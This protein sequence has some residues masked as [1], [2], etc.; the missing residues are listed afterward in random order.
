[1][2]KVPATAPEILSFYGGA[3]QIEKKK[4]GDHYRFKRI[5]GDKKD[6]ILFA[7]SIT[8]NLDKSRALLPWAV[9]LVGAHITMTLEGNGGDR[10]YHRDEIVL[11][12]QEA[13]MKPEEAKVKG[14]ST[15][16]IIHTF[17]HDFAK[18]ILDP[19]NCPMPT[20]DHLDEDNDDEHR[21]AINGINAF[22]DWYNSRKVEFVAMEEVVYY[23]SLLSGDTKEGEHVIE[24]GGIIDLLAKVNGRLGVWDY[25]TGK[26]IYSDQRYQNAGYLKAYNANP[27]FG[28]AVFGGILNF[29]KETGELVMGEYSL[30]EIYR[31]YEFGFKGLYYATVR[32]KELEEERK[33]A[34]EKAKE[35]L[36]K[37]LVEIAE[38]GEKLMKEANEN[39]E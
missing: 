25:K 10:K 3:V 34:S 5:W 2:S 33:V 21:K 24:Y 7:T 12:V 19:K 29:G 31:D 23:N 38:E 27:K 11:L 37:A 4:W 15:G 32:E 30:E 28:S 20:I 39:K 6:S 18:H 8:K 1:M 9:G 36:D 16:D 22:M 14:G 26:A 13:M 35:L 17:A